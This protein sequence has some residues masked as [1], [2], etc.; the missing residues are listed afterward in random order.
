MAIEPDVDRWEHGGPPESSS[1][2]KY[3]TAEVWPL[4]A[5]EQGIWLLSGEGPWPTDPI[6]ADSSAVAECEWELT[7]HG[8]AA[9]IGPHQSS[10]REDGPAGIWTH[11]AVI[12]CQG[13]IRAT[14][15]DAL[16][17][18]PKLVKAVGKPPTHAANAAPAEIRLVDVLHHAL[19]HIAFQ[20]SPWGDAE[21]ADKLDARWRQHLANWT[22]ELY[23]L[24]DRVH[25]SA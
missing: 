13:P 6:H 8:A 23:R 20:L 22:P 19:R 18:P 1:P 21:L 5:D 11:F 25:E 2:L 17:V 12:D 3:L 7:Q 14:W 9:V 24:Y 4:A 16:P 15:P 10:S